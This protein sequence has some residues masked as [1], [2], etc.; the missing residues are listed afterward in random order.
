MSLAHTCLVSLSL[1]KW[2]LI[3]TDMLPK[4]IELV[5][6]AERKEVL[7]AQKAKVP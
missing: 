7:A 1:P 2:M 3:A 6:Y 5:G 4:I